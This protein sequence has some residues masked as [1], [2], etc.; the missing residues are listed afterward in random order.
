MFT[1]SVVALVQFSK[2]LISRRLRINLMGK[3]L[4]T[5]YQFLPLSET[6]ATAGQPTVE[7]F[8][9]I[10]AAGYDVVINLALPESA[11]AIPEEGAIVEKLGLQYIH[12][13]VV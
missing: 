4:T 12:I 8:P 7:Q 11:N 5:I 9:A 2:L 10:Q 3:E 1:Q 13:P 6:I